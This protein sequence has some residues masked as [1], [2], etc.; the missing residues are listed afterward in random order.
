MAVAVLAVLLSL[1]LAPAAR[2]EIPPWPPPAPYGLHSM[3]YLDAPLGF[4]EALFREAA[5]MRAG[6]IRVEVSL[7]AVVPAPG[8]RD[9][10]ALD[11]DLVLARR[12][13]LRVD[14]VLTGTPW[15]LARCHT[16]TELRD[17]YRCPPSSA[18][19]W[20]GY[21]GQ[22]AA[23]GRG[24]IGAWEILNEPDE[25]WAFRGSARDY[26]AMLVAARTAIGRA[27]PGALVVL[28]GLGRLR[29]R[30]WLARVLRAAGRPPREA[31]DVAAVHIRGRLDRL[32][33][34]VGDWRRFLAG[35]GFTGPLWV[36]EHGYP[37][38]RRWQFDPA[39]R[40][41]PPSQAAYLERSVPTLLGAGAEEVFLTER[42]NLHGRFSTEGLLGGDVADPPP[43]LPRIV[44]KPAVAALEGLADSPSA[45]GP[46][47]S[48]PC[49]VV[50]PC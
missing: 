49:A 35:Q 5:A 15:W 26:A 6:W 22:I 39:F 1:L 29:S 44:P 19:A 8:V 48:P 16:E 33:V 7:P 34:K 41:G 32:A 17:T 14:A 31:F 18:A 30:P 47:P 45:T 3:L 21:A 43:L 13:G 9:W 2:A 25:R 36:T 38:D 4:Q 27:D 20:G 46:Q 40:D 23:R 12:Y 11:A 24:V 42:D 50:A 10:R 28:G 37:S